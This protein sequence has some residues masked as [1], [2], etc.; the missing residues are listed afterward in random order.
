MKKIVRLTERDLTRI[1]KRVIKENEE[2]SAFDDIKRWMERYK[3]KAMSDFNTDNPSWS[4]VHH[5]VTL[6]DRI[7]MR[8][9]FNKK[10]DLSDEE[11]QNLYSEYLETFPED[12]REDE[13]YD[14][15]DFY[16]GGEGSGGRW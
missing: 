4:Q 7:R 3:L 14:D 10:F 8:E 1:V 6:D 16:H 2:G 9:F 15:D 11:V 13:D 12:K 5:Q